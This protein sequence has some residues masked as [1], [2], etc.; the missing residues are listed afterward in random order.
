[1][2]QGVY[3]RRGPG[4]QDMG[5]EIAE[6]ESLRLTVSDSGDARWVSIFP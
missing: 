2:K 5:V 1:M 3:K 6:G 4:L